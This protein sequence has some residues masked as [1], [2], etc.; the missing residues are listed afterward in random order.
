MLMAGKIGAWVVGRREAIVLGSI[1]AAA[2]AA[3]PLEAIAAT[4]ES[5]RPKPGDRLVVAD[6][7]QKGRPIAV[8]MLP[9]DGDPVFAWPLEPGAGVVRSKSRFNKVV[10]VRVDPNRLDDKTRPHAAEGVLAFSAVCTH[11]G[12]AVTGWIPEEALLACPC[13]GTTFDVTQAGRVAGGPAK[14]R[15]AILP[16]K[17]EGDGALAVADGFTSRLGYS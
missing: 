10:L 5:E 8:D 14:R 11:Q 13:H 2:C 1:A 15:L 3:C 6:G 16:L 17:V 9:V 12:C 4:P 7:D